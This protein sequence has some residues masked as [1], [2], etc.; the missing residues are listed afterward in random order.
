MK[1]NQLEPLILW[2]YFEQITRIPRPSKHEEKMIAYLQQF[3]SAH[4]LDF[5]TDSAGNVVIRKAACIGYESEKKIILQAHM[6]MVC[7]KNSDTIFD[8]E[9]QA[10]QAYIDGDFVKAKGTT[11][12]ADNGI[13]MAMMLALLS[14]NNLAHPALECLFTADEETGLTGAF[15]LDKQLLKGE[16]LI[17]LDSEDDGEIFIGCAGGMDTTATMHYIE[18]DSPENYFAFQLKVSGLK[19]GHS[20]DDIHRGLANANKV[21]NRYLWNLNQITDLRLHAISGG[22]LR[23]AIAREAQAIA[24][25]PWSEKENV[26]VQLNHFI[27]DVTL[28]YAST[29]PNL[30]ITLESEIMPAKSIDK[31]TSTNLLHALYACAHG[32]GAMS[33]EMPGMVETSTNLASVKMMP[34]HSIVITTSQRSAVNSSKYDIAH[35]VASVFLLAGCTVA[36]GDGYPGWKPNVQSDILKIAEKTHADL[37]SKRA[38]VRSIH[39]GLECGL[40]LEKYPH[41]DMISIGPQMYGVHS[42]EERLSISSTQR[43]WKWLLAILAHKH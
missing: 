41:L 22:N 30:Q 23:N 19:G 13:G 8:F 21:L 10:I 1:I 28:E 3:A 24:S 43:C 25:V 42:P 7:E 35:Q 17:N 26:R 36:H 39:A 38:N 20:G 11:L 9:N 27:H 5:T 18:E 33:V 15:A 12:G 34:N 37:F 2:D 14:D 29:E 40:F 32:V 4:H 6:D 31:K 16:V